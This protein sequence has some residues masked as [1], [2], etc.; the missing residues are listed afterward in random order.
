MK[1]GLW[2]LCVLTLFIV[3]CAPTTPEAPPTA[4]APEPPQEQVTEPVTPAPEPTKEIDSPTRELLAKHEKVTSYSYGFGE[5]NQRDKINVKGDLIRI[6]LSERRGKND[7]ERYD[8]VFLDVKAKTAKGTCEASICEPKYYKTYVEAVYGAHDLEKLP[9]DYLGDI[10][11]AEL[12][13]NTQL[14]ENRKTQEVLVEM[15]DGSTGT[16]WL[17]EFY[18]F[19]FQIELTKNDKKTTIT[20]Y[21]VAINN[22]NDADVKVPSSFTLRQ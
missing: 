11:Y 14:L 6:D 13:K 15:K 17:D 4:P 8:I 16:M 22:L 5:L 19:P 9:L 10:A 20:F 18:G 1:T 21:D 2:I 3:A 7:E 12:G